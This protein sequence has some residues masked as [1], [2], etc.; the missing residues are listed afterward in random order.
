MYDFFILLGD[1]NSR[2]LLPNYN[3][4]NITEQ[5]IQFFR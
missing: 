3:L 4:T 5:S 1:F 2:V